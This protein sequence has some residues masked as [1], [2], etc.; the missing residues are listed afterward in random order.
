MSWK[1]MLTSVGGED[2]QDEFERMTVTLLKVRKFLCPDS[3]KRVNGV[4][5]SL[6]L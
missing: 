4:V 6:L 2:E 3:Q 5:Q 1:L